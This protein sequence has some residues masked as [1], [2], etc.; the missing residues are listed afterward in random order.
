MPKLAWLYLLSLLNIQL[1]QQVATYIAAQLRC[2]AW[3]RPKAGL[4]TGC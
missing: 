3:L 2:E 1:H 4:N